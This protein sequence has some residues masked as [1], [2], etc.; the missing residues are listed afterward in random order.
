MVIAN[1]AKIHQI[2]CVME[3]NK[4]KQK[5]M[6][7]FITELILM[8]CWSSSLKYFKVIDHGCFIYYGPCMYVVNVQ[9]PVSWQ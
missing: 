9:P 6:E 4:T 8:E 1:I 3:A 5:L 2:T 7:R